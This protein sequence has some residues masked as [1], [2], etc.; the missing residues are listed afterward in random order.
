MGTITALEVQQR[1]KE[2]VNI[3]LDGDYAFSLALIEAAKLKKGQN[4]TEDDIRS[5]RDDDEINKAIDRAVRFLAY[6]PR[7]VAEVRQNLAGKHVPEAAI[8][9]TIERLNAM[10][11]L[12]DAAF[13]RYWVENRDTFKPRG[14]VALR[15]ELRQK[16]IADDIIET[17]LA[18]LD[19]T[20]AAFRAAQEK[21]RRLRGLSRREFQTK[22]GSFLQRRGFDYATTQDVLQQLCTQLVESDPDF[23]I[24]DH[25]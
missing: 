24:Q 22:L 12:D 20:D 23:F 9:T 17:T 11:Y 19:T 8:E 4:L 1:N 25:P 16:G 15:Y 3:Y 5:L 18:D 10:G 13:A 6:R 2:R 21:A 14:A 7:S